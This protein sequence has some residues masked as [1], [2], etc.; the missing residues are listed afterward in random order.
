[1]SMMNVFRKLKEYQHEQTSKSVQTPLQQMHLKNKDDL[2]RIQSEIS[3][4][5]GHDIDLQ[6]L[7]EVSVRRL[8]E[9]YNNDE[10]IYTLEHFELI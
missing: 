6:A 4:K 5:V 2:N 9:C 1:M 3:E 10:I 8:V 7:I